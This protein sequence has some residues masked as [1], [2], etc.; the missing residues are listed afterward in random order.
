MKQHDQAAGQPVVQVEGLRKSFGANTV[1]KGVDL[2]IRRGE[3]VVVMGPSG[4]GKTTFIRSLNFLEVPDEG[5]ITI[6][7]TRVAVQ[8]GAGLKREQRRRVREI[9]QKTAMVFQSFNLF[10]HMTVIKNIIEGP[11]QVKGVGKDEAI[12][13]A[14]ALLRQVGLAEKENEYPSRL[15]G[16]QKQRVAIARALAMKPEVI[17]FDEPTSALDPELRDEVLSVMRKLA[18]EGMTMVVVTHEVRFARDVADRVVFMEGGV[19][20]EDAPSAS[21]FDAPASERIRQFLRRVA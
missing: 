8:A 6:C 1:L 18:D 7:G 21:F 15:S 12:Q 16:G 3:V 2:T 9:R 19:V 4:S 13:Q 17:F 20:L 10:S 11:V 14:R 5:A